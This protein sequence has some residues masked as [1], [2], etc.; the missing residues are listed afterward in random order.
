MFYRFDSQNN[1]C[2]DAELVNPLASKD[3]YRGK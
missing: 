1:G 2:V 3:L